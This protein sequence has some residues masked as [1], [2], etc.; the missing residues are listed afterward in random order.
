MAEVI[1]AT[2]NVSFSDESDGTQGVLKLEI[3]DRENGLN[4]GDTSFSPGD[5][6][7]YFLFKDSNVDVL[8]HQVTAGGKTSQGSDTKSLDENIT[9][10]NSDTAS[11]SY[12]PDGAVTLQW[13]GRSFE[14]LGEDVYLNTTL[15][16]ITHS[17]LKMPGGKKIVGI[18]NC[19]YDSTGSLYK[20]SNVPKDFEEALIFAI[21]TIS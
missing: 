19:V 2:L 9:F 6:V 13:L 15:P 5:D 16:E 10:S 1:V 4:G 12:P 17:E 18:L 20:L 3:D 11:L 8:D 14:I 7:Y 21:G